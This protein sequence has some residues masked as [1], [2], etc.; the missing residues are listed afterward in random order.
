M[1]RLKNNTVSQ[2]LLNYLLRP[3]LHPLTKSLAR[4]FRWNLPKVLL[5]SL[6]KRKKK[7]P[8]KIMMM[9]TMMKRV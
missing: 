8:L 1:F 5:R 4:V 7:S 6:A 3:S 2:R 9:S